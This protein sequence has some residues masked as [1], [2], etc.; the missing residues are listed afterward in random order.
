MGKGFYT[1][2]AASNIAKNKKIYFPYILMGAFMVM[3]F[4]IMTALFFNQAVDGNV[5]FML[6]VGCVVTGF[7]GVVF[8][9]YINS[10]V[11]KRRKKEIGLYN[12]LGMEKRHIARMMLC[13]T[14]YVVVF[15]VV[16]GLLFGIIFSKLMFLLLE[17]LIQADPSQMLPFEIPGQAIVITLV[18]FGVAYFVTLIYNL[19]KIHLTKP[20]ELLHGGQIGEKEPKTKMIMTIIGFACLGLGYYFALTVKSPFA[21]V[22]KFLIAV[23]LV[24]VGTY[25]LFTAGSIAIIKMLRKNK[26]FYYKTTHFTNVSGMLY[27][28]KQNAVGLANICILSTMVLISVSTTVC[29]YAGMEDTVKRECPS[30]I[31][32][33]VTFY[34]DV[35]TAKVQSEIDKIC[36]ENGVEQKNIQANKNY[37]VY[38]LKESKSEIDASSGTNDYNF[39]KLFAVML[40]PL[41]EY[42]EMTGM[43]Y[44]LNDNEVL[45]F[46]KEDK[47]IGSE[48]KIKIGDDC[49]S[50]KIKEELKSLPDSMN[51]DSVSDIVNC[52]VMVVKDDNVMRTLSDKINVY[53]Q[54]QGYRKEGISYNYGFETGLSKESSMKLSKELSG[55]ELD[56]MTVYSQSQYEIRDEF[57]QMYGGLLFIGIYVGIIFLMA[58]TL[59]VYYKQISEGYEDKERFEIMQKVGMS[60]AEV[61]KTIKSQVLMV[62]FI[63][64]V[65]A[66]IHVSVAFRIVKKILAILSLGG[67]VG[68]FLLC[69]VISIVIFSII[70]AI[71]FA[72]T[73][74]SYYKIVSV[75]E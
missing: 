22:S 28:M 71:V 69:T 2:M 50:Y 4:Y 54:A 27:R 46:S 56:G 60:H 31:Q 35:D 20:I 73:A 11:M 45:F 43:N 63:P 49:V 12:I 47:N 3:M 10:F 41:N 17:K 34:G 24:I 64:L 6:V 26:K 62:F 32:M 42:N 67:N 7:F 57:H 70:Y 1:K 13:E 36:K 23:L 9:F 52:N 61:K 21:A 48:Y 29:M 19:A 40:I 51:F 8:L 55:I 53:L 5:K 75:N 15:A 16:S 68:L 37:P 14:V 44:T 39:E 18:V 30:E 25:F 58:T 59:I 66:T 33:S 38:G 72:V 65:V 74:K